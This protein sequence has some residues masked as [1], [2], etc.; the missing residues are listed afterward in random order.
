MKAGY[1][2]FTPLPNITH[3]PQLS[4]PGTDRPVVATARGDASLYLFLV[5]RLS[6]LALS[7]T[8]VLFCGSLF[9]KLRQIHRVISVFTHQSVCLLGPRRRVESGA[10][11]PAAA[12]WTA[13]SPAR[14]ITS[15]DRKAAESAHSGLV[16]PSPC[17]KRPQ[18]DTG[19]HGQDGYSMLM[20]AVTR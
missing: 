16:C 3:S 5:S 18:R 2:R 7:C 15:R 12:R 10:F 1:R 20:S 6:L 17:N 14:K 19:G 13:T 4:S 11:P 9:V 8:N